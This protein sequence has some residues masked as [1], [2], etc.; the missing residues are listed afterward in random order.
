MNLRIYEF[1]LEMQLE[2]RLEPILINHKIVNLFHLLIHQLSQ[3]NWNLADQISFV[4]FFPIREQKP[5]FRDVLTFLQWTLCEDFIIFNLKQK[6][7][8]YMTHS[9]SG[10]SNFWWF[11]FDE[12]RPRIRFLQRDQY[13]IPNCLPLECWYIGVD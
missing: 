5:N 12:C 4:V 6:V 11:E 1:Y 3:I 8:F 13:L 9:K 2:F 10:F 7:T